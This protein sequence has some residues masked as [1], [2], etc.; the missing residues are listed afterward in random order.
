[1]IT[2]RVVTAALAI[3]L[4]AAAAPAMANKRTVYENGP[5]SV[6]RI[7]E[8][9]DGPVCS[10][11]YFNPQ[12]GDLTSMK[13]EANPSDW[14]ISFSNPDWNLNYTSDDLSKYSVVFITNAG[15]EI[16]DGNANYWEVVNETTF[17]ATVSEEI[18]SGMA[19]HHA[20]LVVYRPVGSEDPRAAVELVGSSR[21]VNAL[22]NCING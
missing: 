1:M 18:L 3:S 4:T 15:D 8:D 22:N 21:A 17:A 2:K 7:V 14:R 5:W 11:L 6:E 19:R 9:G 20:A 16:S 10:L 13:L 12:Y